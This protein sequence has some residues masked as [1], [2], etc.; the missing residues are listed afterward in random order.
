MEDMVNGTLLDVLVRAM[1]LGR[2]LTAESQQYLCASIFKAVN[3]L[4][5]QV[6]MAH[7]DLKADNCVFN[8]DL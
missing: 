1:K 2:K 7:L 5:K 3:W 6:G 8:N 4:H